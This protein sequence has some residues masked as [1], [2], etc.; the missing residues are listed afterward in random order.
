MAQVT[1]I[2]SF[3]AGLVSFLSPCVL[4]LVPGFLAY[5][6]G[7]SGKEVNRFNIFINSLAFVIGF[8]LVFALLGVLLNTVL[9]GVA[10]SVQKWISRFGGIII[11][12]FGLYILDLIKINFL[13]KE[14]KIMPG[15]IFRFSYFTSFIFGVAFAAGW[16]PCVSAVLGSI[17]AL[18]VSSPGMSF[19]LLVSY[20]IGLGIPFLIVG[21]FSNET[22]GIISK[23]QYVL[24][25]FKIIMGILLIILG[26][27]VFTNSLSLIANLN[28][29]NK[30]LLR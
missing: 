16:T 15:K 23:Y 17:L 3:F 2:I 7:I 13:Q 18:A 12:I 10:Y 20:S 21:L 11:I 4:P 22:L 25:Y 1:L 29:I 5:I 26:I 27:L 24:K 6:S 19:S 8:S 9:E 28:I 14:Y 30:I